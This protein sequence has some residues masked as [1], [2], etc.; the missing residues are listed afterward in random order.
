VAAAAAAAGARV[1]PI[2]T[3]CVF[4]GARGGYVERD[5]HDALDVYGKTKSLGETHHPHVV[6]L[7]CSIVGPEP[8]DR[9]FLLEWL[10]GQPMGAAVRGFVNHRWNGVT[11]L[12]FARLC[13]GLVTGGSWP[14]HLQ[15][16]VPADDVTKADLLRLMAAAYDR[17]DVGI[18]DAAADVPIDRT[19]ATIQPHLNT[20]LWKAAGYAKP[21]TVAEMVRELAGFERRAWRQ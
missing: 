14:G 6:H 17:A 20:R 5:A 10:R 8:K 3:D 11:T 7:R 12:Q 19:L 13:R 1:I 9:K 18:A 2:A 21:P 15:H 16:V 4:S